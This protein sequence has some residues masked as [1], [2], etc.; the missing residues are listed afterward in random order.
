MAPE[1]NALASKGHARTCE[2]GP[3][4]RE[5]GAVAG[6]A[7]AGAG[8]D[9]DSARR[10]GRAS[11]IV[12]AATLSS[13]AAHALPAMPNAPMSQTSALAT[14]ATAPSVFQP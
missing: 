9:C 8:D 1:R 12:A 14:P 10:V 2:S 4:D 5:A 7:V 13:P 6:H 3:S 11:A